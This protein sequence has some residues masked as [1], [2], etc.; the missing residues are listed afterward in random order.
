M[1]WKRF[2][3][4]LIFPP[5]WL[6]VLLT[7]ASAAGLILVFTREL[8]EHPVAYALYAVSFY[9][10]CVL[11]VFF[12]LVLPKQYRTMREKVYAHPIGHR[13][14]T[15]PKF[16]TGVKLYMSLAVNL[17]YVGVNV[18][19]WFL[20]RSMW[21][22][23]LGVYYTILAVMR[24]LLAGYVRSNGIGSNYLGELKR[25]RLCSCIL[26]L[27]NFALSGAVLMILYQNR[28]YD[29]HG[30]L[31]YVMASYTFYITIHAIVDLAKYRKYKSPVMT[32][33]KVVALT[34]ALVSMLNLET[35]M[36]HQFGGEMA[37]Q[38]QRLMI[39]LTGAGVS[40]A[41]VAM[42]IFMIIRT[43]KEIKEIK[44]DGR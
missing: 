5:G 37:S 17:L 4:K 42:S 31:I 12:A 21:F 30:I 16:K 20:Y 18:L 3:N 29:Y 2:W 39:A 28:G 32:A 10:V 38:D 11:T 27:V 22:V 14:L 36:F 43:A 26:L 8:S 41:V 19:S 24:F 6:T 33:S 40:I 23:V 44:H 13:Y 34:A 15:D 25:A 35:A 7:V 1:D 9:T